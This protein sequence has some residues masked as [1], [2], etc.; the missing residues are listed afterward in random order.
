MST[1]IATYIIIGVA[2]N[3]A[4]RNVIYEEHEEL[5]FPWKGV[6]AKGTLGLLFDGM[7]D[8]PVLAGFCVDVADDEGGGIALASF[9]LRDLVPS[10]T[11]IS[12]DAWLK[13]RG[14]DTL[15][16]QPIQLHVVT[17]FS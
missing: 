7:G 9:N 16:D 1:N 11:E 8:D 13:E 14:L 3:L 15:T 5:L 17:N 12:V 2:L 10:E 6:G 4:D